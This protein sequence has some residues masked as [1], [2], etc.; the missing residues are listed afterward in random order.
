V[1]ASKVLIIQREFFNLKITH[2]DTDKMTV[3]QEKHQGMNQELN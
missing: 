2:D 1:K 3:I